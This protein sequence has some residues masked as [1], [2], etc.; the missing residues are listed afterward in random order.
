M[1]APTWR[2]LKLNYY[3]LYDVEQPEAVSV[4]IDPAAEVEAVESRDFLLKDISTGM[5]EDMSRIAA[6]SGA[7]VHRF[8]IGEQHRASSPVRMQVSY[9]DSSCQMV[10][11]E[12]VLGKKSRMT[13]IMDLTSREEASGL[14]ASQIRYRLDDGAHL[15]IIQ[16]LHASSEYCVLSDIGGECGENSTFELVQIVL[17][18]KLN[19]LGMNSRLL[20]K[21]SSL[22]TRL[23]YMLDGAGYLDVNYVADHVGRHTTCDITA[24]GVL[25]D[26]SKKVFRGTIDFKKGCSGAVGSET[27]DV[28]IMDD[29]C[30]NQTIPVILC[31]E[32]DVEGTHGATIGKLSEDLL[33]YLT[34]RGM[35]EDSVYEMMARARIDS[36]ADH[37]HDD[38]IRELI[39]DELDD[40]ADRRKEMQV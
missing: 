36:V 34:S 16:V 7:P 12:L 18:G 5:G 27:E 40:M 19:F 17:G 10:N 4:E 38:M 28:L 37:I 31:S 22:I 3:D 15:T 35:D 39:S 8:T 9:W 24:N 21:R 33:F 25:R 1:P 13:F 2:W 29:E 23:G 14:G 11:T 32:E 6:S 30:I 20:G 26:Q